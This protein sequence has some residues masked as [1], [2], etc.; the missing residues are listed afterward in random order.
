MDQWTN[1]NL[2]DDRSL[3]SEFDS[4]L[5]QLDSRL[6][7]TA[8]SAKVP[9]GLS[10][11]VFQA[12]APLLSE[13]PLRLSTPAAEP[14]PAGGSKLWFRQSGAGM[15]L[16]ATIALAATA[17]IWVLSQSRRAPQP[18]DMVATNE[19]HEIATN[20]TS[21]RGDVAQPEASGTSD[22]GANIDDQ[23]LQALMASANGSLDEARYLIDTQNMH[24]DEVRGE[25]ERIFRELEM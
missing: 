22:S 5:R 16:A 8:R 25:V 12:S 9:A 19:S 1:T 4:S 17:G 2:N 6:L 10:E 21:H 23:W 11:R 13:R 7:Q 20:A 3:P 18:N 24:Y 14:R 15:R